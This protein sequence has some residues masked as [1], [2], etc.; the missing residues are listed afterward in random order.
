MGLRQ[1]YMDSERGAMPKF[2]AMR[3]AVGHR[4]RDRE[5][6][7]GGRFFFAPIRSDHLFDNYINETARDDDD[8]DY[9]FAIGVFAGLFVGKGHPFEFV[10]GCFGRDEQ[11]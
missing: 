4:P 6:V 8:L 11:T 2:F 10:V 3:T 7:T 1:R 5:S 9:F